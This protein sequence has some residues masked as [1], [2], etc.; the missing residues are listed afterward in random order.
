[1][2]LMRR[3]ASILQLLDVDDYIMP[4]S[5]LLQAKYLENNP[6]CNVVRTNGYVVEENN[7][8]DTSRLLVEYQ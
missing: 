2:R 7:L 1:M 4:E 6:Q 8:E 3:L 5:C